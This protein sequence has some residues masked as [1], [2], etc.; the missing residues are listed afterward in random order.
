M[1]QY[2]DKWVIV[3]APPHGILTYT[4]FDTEA[5][6]RKALDGLRRSGNGQ[7]AYLQL[8]TAGSGVFV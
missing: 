2:T 8:P 7:H 5:A 3:N 1:N 4:S 6:A